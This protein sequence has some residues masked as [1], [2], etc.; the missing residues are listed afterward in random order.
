MSSEVDEIGPLLA[1]AK[2]ELEAKHR[3]S[4]V[5][6]LSNWAQT[7]G[8]AML[9]L[10]AFLGS[11]GSLFTGGMAAYLQYGPKPW[12]DSQ[13]RMLAAIRVFEINNTAAMTT[14]GGLTPRVEKLEVRTQ[15]HGEALAS[16]RPMV[17]VTEKRR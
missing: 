15:L 16:L 12:E 1:K 17:T 5:P 8:K 10:F 13:A 14:V 2:A 3:H 4:L 7:R 11:A 9:G 6:A